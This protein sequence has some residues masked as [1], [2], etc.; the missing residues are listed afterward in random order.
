M[1][2]VSFCLSCWRLVLSAVLLSVSLFYPPPWGTPD[3]FAELKIPTH[4]IEHEAEQRAEHS[5]EY[6]DCIHPGHLRLFQVHESSNYKERWRQ[7]SLG[8][9]SKRWR[10]SFEAASEM[11]N[12]FTGP[13]DHDPST[14]LANT[15]NLLSVVGISTKK[16]TSMGELTR[17]ASSMFVAIFEALFHVRLEG[18]I[19]NPQNRDEYAHNAQRVIDRWLRRSIFG[20]DSNAFFN[21]RDFLSFC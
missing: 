2:S 20:I 18:I 6:G 17:V 13:V 11:V 21:Y 14:V 8:S 15:N 9:W 5:M 19:R 4:S 7:K 3:I 12:R 1:I 16:V 10:R